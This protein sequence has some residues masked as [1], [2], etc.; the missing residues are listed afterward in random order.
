M[1]FLVAF[2]LALAAGV[3]ALSSRR[4]APTRSPNAAVKA[5]AK[6]MTLLRPVFVAEAK[7]QANI[8]G[9]SVNSEEVAKEI[10]TEVKTKPIVIYTYGLSPFSTEALAILE[11]TGYDYEKIE[12]GAEWFLLGAKNSVKRVLL[13]EQVESGATSLP[14]VFVNGQ[15]IGG[16]A[17]LAETVESGGLDTLMKKGGKNRFSF[18]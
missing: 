11:S 17:E 5:M 8:L 12:L 3:S 7:V 1:K 13:S 14:K 4:K 6:G 15:C 18:L 9:G 2:L 16:C 10:A